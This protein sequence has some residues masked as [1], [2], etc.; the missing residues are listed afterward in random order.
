MV[1]HGSSLLTHLQRSALLSYNHSILS[2]F[3]DGP[4]GGLRSAR[5]AEALH[6]A[7]AL[8]FYRGTTLM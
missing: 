7:Y 8:K 5:G 1:G 3:L 2:L 6:T 4:H